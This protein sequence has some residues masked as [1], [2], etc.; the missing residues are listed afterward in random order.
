MRYGVSYMLPHYTGRRIQGSLMTG[1][2]P[3]GIVPGNPQK[4][5]TDSVDTIPIVN[6]VPR[7]TS[8]YLL[9]NFNYNHIRKLRHILGPACVH[10]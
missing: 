7:E 8:L 5:R 10:S 4:D 3:K 1:F 9:W 6:P 2:T